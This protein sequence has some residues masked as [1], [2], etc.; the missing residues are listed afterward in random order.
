[1]EIFFNWAKIFGFF[2]SNDNNNKYYVYK[3]IKINVDYKKLLIISI[4]NIKKMSFSI[5]FSI[6]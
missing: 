1:M 5:L 3:L 2:I 6:G 4:I